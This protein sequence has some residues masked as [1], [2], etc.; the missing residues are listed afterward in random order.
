MGSQRKHAIAAW[1][2]YKFCASDDT[3]FEDNDT[4]SRPSTAFNEGAL[5]SSSQA[6]SCVLAR[7]D[8]SKH[9]FNLAFR[10]P[11]SFSIFS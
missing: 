9:M 3:R 11:K 8:P 7:F 1:F 5:K 2:Q 10:K 6:E 4:P